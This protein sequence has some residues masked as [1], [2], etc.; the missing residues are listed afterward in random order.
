M[1]LSKQG[2]DLLLRMC[3]MC[4]MILSETWRSCLV[5]SIFILPNPL[6]QSQKVRKFV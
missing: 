1:T 5:S 2:S 6:T 3:K 4:L